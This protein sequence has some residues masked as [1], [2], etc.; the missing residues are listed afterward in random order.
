MTIH[1]DT[2]GTATVQPSEEVADVMYNGLA[3]LISAATND[4]ELDAYLTAAE[5]GNGGP[6][7]GLRW[8]MGRWRDL[9]ARYA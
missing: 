3:D 7:E 9:L 2:Q 6:L 4:A 8:E 1:I 5:A